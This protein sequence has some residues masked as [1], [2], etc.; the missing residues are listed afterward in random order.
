MKGPYHVEVEIT[1]RC[2]LHCVH[3]SLRAGEEK[4]DLPYE[5]YIELVE[6]CAELGVR[7]FDVIGGEPLA[8]QDIYELLRFA[9]DKI[10]KVIVNTSGYFLNKKIINNLKKARIKD[11][12]VSLDGPD[13]EKHEMIR[14]NGRNLFQKTCEGIKL[15]VKEGFKT[16]VAFVVNKINYRD[17]PKMVELCSTLGVK[18]LFIL[19]FIPTGRGAEQQK[20]LLVPKD[21][22]METLTDLKRYENNGKVR[23]MVDCSM[24]CVFY[25]L[26]KNSCPAGADFVTVTVNGDVFPCG[27]LRENSEFKLGNIKE[28]RFSDIWG[29]FVTRGYEKFKKNLENYYSSLDNSKL[30]DICLARRIYSNFNSV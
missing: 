13:P 15:L 27:F 10:P 5:N 21:M 18:N 20:E 9:T 1:L 25:E 24:D 29:D 30:K 17:I 11:I 4:T 16:T 8:R 28:R 26:W 7:I 19:G 2:P 3:C 6:D 14:G 23:I 12:F 22:L